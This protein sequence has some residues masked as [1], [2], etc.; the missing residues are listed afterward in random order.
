MRTS[1]GKELV[2]HLITKAGLSSLH[3]RFRRLRGQNVDHLFESSLADRFSA[4][5][6]NGVWLNK[7]NTTSL[8]G[9]GS[10]I[11]A[12]ESVRMQLPGLLE[13]LACRT[14][15]DIGCGDFNWMKEVQLKCSYIGVDIVDGVIREN[16][17]RYSSERRAFC[18]I[19]ATRE[20]L[21]QADTVLCRE[22]LFHLSMEHIRCLVSNVR[23]S[24]ASFLIATTD[25]RAPLNAEIV[26]G[27]FV[28]LTLS[29]SPFFFPAPLALIPDD[30]AERGRVLA[31][32]SVADL[33]FG[34]SK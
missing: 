18:T 25:N 5:Y 15:L 29:K 21:P 22:V 13:S 26:S 34:G 30:G 23:Q 31:A 14:L 4:I 27:D 10:E 1:S 32:W 6:R 8:S 12:T 28:L 17:A 20:P 19:D 33:R 24:G 11:R 2:R 16:S 7:P 9:D 3:F